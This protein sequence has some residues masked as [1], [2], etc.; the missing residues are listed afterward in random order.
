MTRRQSNWIALAALFAGA[1]AVEMFLLNAL[2]IGMDRKRR[3]Y[4]PENALSGEIQNLIFADSPITD[5]EERV[6]KAVKQDDVLL[7]SLCM[8]SNSPRGRCGAALILGRLGKGGRNGVAG[9]MRGLQHKDEYTRRAAASAL[10]QI[11]EFQ[12]VVVPALKR[13]LRDPD[14]SVQG[15]AGHALTQFVVSP[16]AEQGSTETPRPRSTEK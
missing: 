10:G 14:K 7:I 3:H 11:G 16:T 2:S 13:C 8:E 6:R 1:L 9:L 15:A 12:E 4:A 5:F